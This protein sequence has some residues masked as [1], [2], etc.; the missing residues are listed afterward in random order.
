MYKTTYLFQ[1]LHCIEMMQLLCLHSSI[2]F[3]LF[4]SPT[5][6][7]TLQHSLLFSLM[8]DTH[9]EDLFCYW[10]L[11]LVSKQ[12]SWR[13]QQ[14]QFQKPFLKPVSFRKKTLKKQKLGLLWFH[15]KNTGSIQTQARKI[16]QLANGWL[17][18]KDGYASTR[19]EQN[20]MFARIPSQV[21]FVNA[22]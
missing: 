16:L 21:S 8:N 9:K 19:V 7:Q 2:F 17:K 5:V 11:E 15:E 3:S 13:Q 4:A 12:A 18:V 6:L 22:M 10:I 14:R 1:G 20:T